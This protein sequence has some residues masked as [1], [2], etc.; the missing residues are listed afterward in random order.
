MFSPPVSLWGVLIKIIGHMGANLDRSPVFLATWRE[1]KEHSRLSIRPKSRQKKG[2]K[3]EKKK[4]WWH[5]C[6][7][8]TMT[9]LCW[10]KVKQIL[11][12]HRKKKYLFYFC[13]NL[14]LCKTHLNGCINDPF[15]YLFSFQYWGWAAHWIVIGNVPSQQS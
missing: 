14:H 5:Q 4:V 3:I 8:W 15:I 10:L 13:N 1:V 9:F 11:I 6:G 12:S 7:L 2:V